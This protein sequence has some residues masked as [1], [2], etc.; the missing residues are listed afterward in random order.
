MTPLAILDCFDVGYF[1]SIVKL[2][3]SDCTIIAEEYTI[4]YRDILMRYGACF[5]AIEAKGIILLCQ[6]LIEDLLRDGLCVRDLDF[7]SFY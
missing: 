3:N 4:V 5:T 1:D 6:Q 2:M 7:G